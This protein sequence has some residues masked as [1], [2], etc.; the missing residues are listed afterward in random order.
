[1]Q[2]MYAKKL[3]TVYLK[4]KFNWIPYFTWQPY[5]E[6]SWDQDRPHPLYSFIAIL[7]SEAHKTQLPSGIFPVGESREQ[8]DRLFRSHH[9]WRPI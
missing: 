9:F 8:T 5:W 3:F 2:Y 7:T 6:S 1:M 4:F